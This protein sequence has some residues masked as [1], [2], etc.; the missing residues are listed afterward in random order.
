[1]V[2]FELR[3]WQ[4]SDLES[5]VKHAN[6]DRIARFL[7]DQ[8]PYPYTLQNGERFL[9]NVLSQEPAKILAI[10]VDGNAVGSIGVF[11]QQDI[12]CLNAEMGYWLSESCQG[13]GIMSAAIRLMVEYGFRTFS[14]D[15]IFARP[16]G[17][18]IASQR[19]LEKA[20]FML[21]AR[22]PDSLLK[23]GEILDELV[24]GI[25]RSDFFCKPSDKH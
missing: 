20:G 3:K 15:R 13:R 6:N 2:Q 16:F 17:S 10:A 9:D 23:N 12:H 24:Y 19:V 4:S 14:V 21:E 7:T 8:F 5:L 25:R 11:P 1:M 18:N 22:F